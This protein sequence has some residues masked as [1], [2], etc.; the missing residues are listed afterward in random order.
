MFHIVTAGIA[1]VA[2]VPKLACAAKVLLLD[3][4]QVSDSSNKLPLIVHIC[5]MI[6]GLGRT[7]GCLPSILAIVLP[8]CKPT[9][10]PFGIGKRLARGSIHF[11][12]ARRFSSVTCAPPALAG[13]L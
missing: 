4:W 9:L 7:L 5:G 1:L 2:Q 10:R 6:G 12:V 11:L 8:S 3:S 13:G